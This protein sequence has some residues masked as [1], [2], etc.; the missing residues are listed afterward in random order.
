MFGG[1]VD[2]VRLQVLLVVLVVPRLLE[3]CQFLLNAAWRAA[4]AGIVCHLKTKKTTYVII[5]GVQQIMGDEGSNQPE[6]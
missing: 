2:V 1:Q 6:W 5:Y 4:Q 3:G